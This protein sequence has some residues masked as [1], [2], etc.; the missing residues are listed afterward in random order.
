MV[1]LCS[2]SQLV[3][4]RKWNSLKFGDIYE[5]TQSHPTWSKLKLV[6]CLS[7]KIALLNQA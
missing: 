3:M 2:G 7:L 4:V 5:P 6:N 1:E